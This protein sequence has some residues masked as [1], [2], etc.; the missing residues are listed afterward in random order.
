[1]TYEFQYLMGMTGAYAMGKPLPHPDQELD[2]NRF[3]TLAKEQVLDSVI[4]QALKSNPDIP[5]P[6]ALL[7][8]YMPGAELTIFGS[9]AKRL[10]L[11]DL[12]NKLEQEGIRAAVVKG[13]VAAANYAHPE[14][15]ISSDTDLLIDPADEEKACE[16]FSRYG[17][18]V[19]PRWKNGHHAIAEHKENRETVEIHVQLY[20][21]LI[22]DIWFSNVDVAS[23]VQQPY[24]RVTIA[25]GVCTT[26]GDTDNL[27]F[28]ALHTVKHFIISGMSL[29]MIIDVALFF[30]KH[31]QA[32]DTARFWA[33]MKALKYDRLISAI[34]HGLIRYCGFREEDFPGIGADASEQ[35]SAILDDL[36]AGGWLG[37][38]NAA[39][40]AQGW[41]EYNRQIMMRN[42]NKFQYFLYMFNWHHGINIHTLFPDRKHLSDRYPCV[43]KY[44]FLIPFIWIH[45][46]ISRGFALLFRKELPKGMVDDEN[47][48]SQES[49]Q[50][51]ALFQSLDML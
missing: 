40:R 7:H 8:K 35:S 17:F 44:P 46:L 39:Q 9:C 38:N 48:I 11:L 45:R 32:I 33:V 13:F 31:K 49:K 47:K 43:Q 14:C 51:V 12:L 23:L 50:R 18:T 19:T 6:P 2:W 25:E 20:D 15:R 3:L 26:L 4:F 29:R 36:E 24:Q 37:T 10:W 1:M 34:L 22:E 28:M 5:C 27:I 42:K 21:E 41:Q 30:A 16:F